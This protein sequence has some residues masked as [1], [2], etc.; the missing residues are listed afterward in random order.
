MAD[1]RKD[2]ALADEIRSTLAALDGGRGLEN[3]ARLYHWLSGTLPQGAARPALA[4]TVARE[5]CAEYSAET[6]RRQ[7]A[8]ANSAYRSG[9]ASAIAGHVAAKERSAAIARSIR[10]VARAERLDR[11]EWLST[12]RAAEVRGAPRAEIGMTGRVEYHCPKCGELLGYRAGLRCLVCD[13]QGVSRWHGAAHYGASD[14]E[15]QAFARVSA[16]SRKP[17][18]HLS[19]LAH[20]GAPCVKVCHG[21]TQRVRPNARQRRKLLRLLP[22]LAD[23]SASNAMRLEALTVLAEVAMLR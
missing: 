18:E 12:R 19:A 2:V 9:N 5:A 7:S 15:T 16:C 3:A 1:I 21:K 13:A 8:A 10:G 6:A 17:V 22:K 4:V 11:D 14:T 23:G 20:N